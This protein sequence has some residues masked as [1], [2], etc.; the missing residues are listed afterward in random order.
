MN[1]LLLSWRNIAAKPLAATL[2]LMLLALGTGMIALLLLFGAQ[3]EKKF[4]DNIKGID[5]VVG[6]K[7][8]PLQLIL[9]SVYHID[10]PTGNIPKAEADRLLR[11]PLVAWGIPLA[12]GDN[13]KGYKIL[14]T[15]PK[16]V[17]FYKGK[18]AEGTLWTRPMQATLGATAAEAMGLEVGGTFFGAHGL[19][20]NSTDIHENAKYE[21]VGILEKNGSVLDLL[22]LTQVESVWE[23]HGE[24]EEAPVQEKTDPAQQ[25]PAGKD[26]KIALPPVLPGIE[27]KPETKANEEIT[28]LLLHFRGPMGIIMLPRL[29]NENTSMQSAVPAFEINRLFSLMGIGVDSLKLLAFIIMLV[30]G[31]SVFISLYSSLKERKYELALMRV[32]GASR[33]K[34]LGLILLEGVVLSVVGFVL[35]EVFARTGMWALARYAAEEYHYDFNILEINPNEPY[36]FALTV[37]VGILAATLPAVRAF[38][39]DISQTLADK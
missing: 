10:Y 25:Q 27:M 29:I 15:T 35:G 20:K 39:T 7:G 21:V 18:L 9:S 14:G 8:S 23:I 22:I 37:G 31:A 28:A 1:L 17:E 11:H 36:L 6:A 12:F 32:M 30:A 26:G 38:R 13:Y 19:D 5:M 33:A 34:L 4:S 24:H 3:L 2:S 16:Y